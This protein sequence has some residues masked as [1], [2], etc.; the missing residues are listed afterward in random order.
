MLQTLE[1]TLAIHWARAGAPCLPC[2][3]EPRTDTAKLLAPPQQVVSR[4]PGTPGAGAHSSQPGLSARSR[5]VSSRVTDDTC[6]GDNACS[7]PLSCQLTPPSALLLPRYLC[8]STGLV[9]EHTM[10]QQM[11]GFLPFNSIVN[12]LHCP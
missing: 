5:L 2:S 6:S 9:G 8:C 4:A 10:L 3:V 7:E 11:Q 12:E 1:P